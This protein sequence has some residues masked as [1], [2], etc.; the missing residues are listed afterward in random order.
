MVVVRGD[1]DQVRFQHVPI[2]NDR[3]G[4]TPQCASAMTTEAPVRWGTQGQDVWVAGT[5]CL[6]FQREDPGSAVDHVD[7]YALRE[8]LGGRLITAPGAKNEI[9]FPSF[10]VCGPLR[11][12]R[13]VLKLVPFE[14]AFYYDLV[15]SGEK[16]IRIAV[17]TDARFRSHPDA[18]SVDL[19]AT[20]FSQEELAKRS[21]SLT[22]FSYSNEWDP[23]TL[24]WGLKGVTRVHE[25]LTPGFCESFQWLAR[26]NTYYFVTASGKLYATTT[27]SFWTGR[28]RVEPLWEDAGRPI[29]HFLTD[30]DA[31]RT[32]LF[33][34][35]AKPGELGVFFEL[36]DKPEPKPYDLSKIK[37]SKADEPLKGAVERSRF[38]ADRKLL[39]HA[40]PPK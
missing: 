3:V 8:L 21:L 5:T 6:P 2:L 35:P 40:E 7:R 19:E 14:A 4:Q 32:F 27:R 25:S 36:G 18:R 24:T 9:P 12:V 39:K 26:G 22:V 33:T 1:E 38:L 15:P 31:D 30:A 17:L 13:V 37:A 10:M 29:T 20:K 23:K 16:E 11:Q 34:K 28:R